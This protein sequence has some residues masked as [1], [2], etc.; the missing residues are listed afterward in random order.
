[1][2]VGRLAEAV[3]H[4]LA[5]AEPA[6]PKS[7]PVLSG[8]AV[9]LVQTFT[10]ML[11]GLLPDL[12]AA[13][14]GR[15][16]KAGAVFAKLLNDLEP[17]AAGLVR[18]KKR[19]VEGGSGE[20]EL[21]QVLAAL[22]GLAPI[23]PAMDRRRI[24]LRRQLWTNLCLTLR[25]HDAAQAEALV[26][27]RWI[28]AGG[29]EAWAARRLG[30]LQ[31]RLG[32]AAGAPA[33]PPATR[34]RKSEASRARGS[35]GPYMFVFPHIPKTGGS[36]LANGL[37]RMLGGAR[38]QAQTFQGICTTIG[39]QTLDERAST[40]LISGHF[41]FDQAEDVL[42]PWLDV[43]PLYLGVVRA[44]VARARSLYNFMG[45]GARQELRSWSLRAEFD[46]DVNV[47]VE[48]W[49]AARSDWGGWRHDQCRAICGEPDAKAAIRMIEERYLGVVATRKVNTLI[50]A[51][52]RGLGLPRPGRMHEKNTNSAALPLDPALAARLRAYHHQDQILFEWVEANQG[53]LLERCEARLRKL[54]PWPDP[55]G[56]WRPAQ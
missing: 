21:D 54:G 20:A 10:G 9:D 18:L 41:G 28:G 6:R 37:A 42:V 50:G 11:T 29:A 15:G 35:S 26:L 33:G 32:Q 23:S 25:D 56:A 27:E 53:R 19:L 39:M 31:E 44:P 45:R 52:A 3:P 5:L 7:G 34:R 46:P 43:H 22:A 17:V 13:A 14:L 47:V 38:L 12:R 40:R 24:D 8:A 48:Q 49:L 55:A 30:R 1:M 4:L 2:R 36:S 16:D 51:V